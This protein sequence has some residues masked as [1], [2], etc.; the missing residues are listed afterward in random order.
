MGHVTQLLGLA[1][2]SRAH[3]PLWGGHSEKHRVNHLSLSS[4]GTGYIA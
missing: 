1:E 4:E 2:N 3:K